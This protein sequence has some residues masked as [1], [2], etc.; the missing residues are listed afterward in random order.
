MFKIKRNISSGQ[1]KRCWLFI[2]IGCTAFML[3][4]LWGKSRDVAFVH[5]EID[6]PHQRLR[7]GLYSWK[8]KGSQRYHKCVLALRPNNR[9][10]NSYRD[11]WLRKCSYKV[12]A[13]A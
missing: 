1:S 9:V 4:Q 6:T 12:P 7:V 10:G 3:K 5:A 2:Q 11:R 13:L 8:K